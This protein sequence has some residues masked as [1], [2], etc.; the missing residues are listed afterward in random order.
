MPQAAMA[1]WFFYAPCRTP[2]I[3]LPTGG[4]GA[5]GGG[6]TEVVLGEAEVVV[7][8]T[9]PPSGVDIQ[10][11]NNNLDVVQFQDRTFLAWR[12]APTHFA[13]ADTVMY[14]ASEGADGWRFEGSF[15]LGTDVREPRF[16]ALGDKLFLYFAV[17]GSDPFAFEPQ[18]MKVTEYHGPGDWDEPEDLYEPGFIPWRAKVIGDKAYLIGYVG[19][20]N[21]Y[22]NNGDPIRIH[23]LTTTDG[24]TLEPVVEGQPVVQEGG[25]SET[26]FTFLDDGT[27]VAVTRDEAGDAEFGFGSKI[28][29]AEAGD[30]GN[31]TC[32]PDPK[33][34]DSPLVFRHQGDV[35]LVGRRN[36]TED[37]NYDLGADELS[38]ADQADKYEVDYSF[39]PKRCAL[40]KVDPDD[41]AVTFVTDLPSRGDTCFASELQKSDHLFTIYNYSSYL[42]GAEDCKSWPDDCADITWWV[43]QGGKTMI[44][45]IDA[46]FSAE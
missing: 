27:L 14:V 32:K 17:L 34:Y 24:R 19:G 7:P 23:F 20:E 40:W 15:A 38:L 5:G 30:L 3:D 18:G 2:D 1:V 42:D 21:I 46:A 45:R 43:G 4:G 33:K 13:S 9:D 8:F 28:C 29:R 12:T 35:W 36:V 16:L 44:Y 11:A 6:Q 41:L 25:G 26:D 39:K 22:E 31:W 37:G 10:N